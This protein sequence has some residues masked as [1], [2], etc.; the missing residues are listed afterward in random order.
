MTNDTVI[1]PTDENEVWHLHSKP[2]TEGVHPDFPHLHYMHLR[3]GDEEISG[4]LPLDKWQ[5]VGSAK[6]LREALD[7]MVTAH[8]AL[9]S[10]TEGQYPP[11]D[12]GCIE[13]TVGTVPDRLNTGL[14]AYHN[15]KKVLGYWTPK[16]TRGYLGSTV[17]GGIDDGP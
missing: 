15:A 17:D 12:S 3:I 5:L 7:R 8:D 2:T 9:S 13:C 4:Y 10:N 1:R 11:L 14:C 6:D 16:R